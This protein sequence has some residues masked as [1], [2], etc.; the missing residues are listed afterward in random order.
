[1]RSGSV[2]GA[3]MTTFLAPACEVL[4]RVGRSVNSPVDSIDDVDAEI[5]PREVGGVALGE[6]L[7]LV[8]VDA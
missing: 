8:P 4:F 3:E 7:D 6:K 1:M 2:A 5:R